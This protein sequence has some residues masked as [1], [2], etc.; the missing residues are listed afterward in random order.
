MTKMT[1]RQKAALLREFTTDELRRELTKREG[2]SWQRETLA[3]LLDTMTE[4]Q[5]RAALN[6]L[7]AGGDRL[8]PSPPRITHRTERN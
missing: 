4:P 5:V 6:R 8:V 7:W 3:S 1:K 2:K